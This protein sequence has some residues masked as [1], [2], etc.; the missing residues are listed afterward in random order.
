MKIAPV[1]ADLLIKIAAALAVLV[2]GYV[3]VKKAS[4]AVSAGVTA[5]GETAVNAVQ[6][7]NPMNNENV[8]YQ[9]ANTATGGTLDRPLGVRI[10]DF[11]HSDPLQ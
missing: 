2:V 8:I 6:A 1:S 11:F 5:I 3:L 7:V 10:Y 4:G 9:A